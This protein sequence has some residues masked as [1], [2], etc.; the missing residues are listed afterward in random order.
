MSAEPAGLAYLSDEWLAA[1]DAALAVLTPV[2]GPLVV[3]FTVTG[4]PR[5]DLSHQLILGPDR[6]GA[7]RG[8]AAATVTLTMH[9][10]LAA[11]ISRGHTSAQRAVLDGRIEVG[12]D[13][14]VLLGYQDHLAE[15]DDVLDT[16]RAATVY[17]R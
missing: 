14:V 8:T 4:G 16:L 15:V 17:D 7:E 13:P 3:G 12:G 6:V 1:A 2:P 9:W 10:N 5:G 11:D